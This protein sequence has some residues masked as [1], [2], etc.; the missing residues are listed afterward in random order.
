M[1]DEGRRFGLE[2]LT[3]QVSQGQSAAVQ[4]G[5]A[6]AWERGYTAALDGNVHKYQVGDGTEILTGGW[7]Q[8]ATLKGYDEY[9]RTFLRAYE[10]SS[11]VVTATASGGPCCGPCVAGLAPTCCC[12][13]QLLQDC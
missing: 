7:P 9:A 10:R 2:P 8:T 6:A 12:S 5:F 11:C 4:Q 1:L 3:D 13:D